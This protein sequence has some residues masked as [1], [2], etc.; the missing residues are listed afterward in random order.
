MKQ[1]LMSTYSLRKT[2]PRWP[3]HNACKFVK[4]IQ[5]HPVLC[6]NLG[7]YCWIVNLIGLG[8][9]VSWLILRFYRIFL[10]G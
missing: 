4:S 8:I 7:L 6:R 5:L 9:K 1:T 2:A 10:Q 3:P